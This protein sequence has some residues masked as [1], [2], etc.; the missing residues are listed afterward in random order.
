MLLP[1]IDFDEDNN[2]I[3]SKDIRQ[4]RFAAFANREVLNKWCGS[5][6]C[7]QSDNGIGTENFY[8]EIP[9]CEVQ[10]ISSGKYYWGEEVSKKVQSKGYFSGCAP[11]TYANFLYEDKTAVK[12]YK[13]VFYPKSDYPYKTRLKETDEKIEE[14]VELMKS[15]D[16]ENTIYIAFPFDWMFAYIHW[17]PQ[18]IREKTYV[19]GYNG[20][21]VSWIERLKKVLLRSECIY[22]PH[23]FSTNVAY[24]TLLDIPVKFYSHDL[25]EIGKIP[26]DEP[27]KEFQELTSSIYTV[28]PSER[29]EKWNGFMKYLKEC[30]ETDCADKYWW[31]SKFL[32]LEKLK[33]PQHL[34]EDLRIL[35]NNFIKNVNK[36]KNVE[37]LPFE[38]SHELFD[39]AKEKC[40]RIIEL[41]KGTSQKALNY[42]KEI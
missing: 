26:D 32:S 9:W 18:E 11:F 22:V 31:T 30:Y 2:I 15:F 19:L 27:N 36:Y 23:I 42:L 21:D 3:I 34:Y 40:D 24:A 12:K 13:T 4:D 6:F 8:N 37:V 41:S 14:A 10:G 17:M 1:I 33:S 35:H 38:T 16:A 29:D 28:V 25:Y 39:I 5:N 7:F 20:F